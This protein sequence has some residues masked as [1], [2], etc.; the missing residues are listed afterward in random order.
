MKAN[1][2][3][4][5][6]ARERAAAVL[7]Q[8]T[9]REL[10]SPEIDFRSPHLSIQGI[11]TANDDGLIVGQGSF[12]GQPAVIISTDGHFLGGGIGEAGGAKFACALE[13]ALEDNKN[14][15]PTLPIILLDTGGVRLQEANYGLLAISEIQSLV[16]ELRKY[17][18]VIG[19][20]PGRIGCFGGMAM[21]ASLF[22]YLIMTREG[23][24]TLNGP[25]VIQLE[26]GVEEFDASNKKLI[27]DTFGV[28]SRLANG[29]ADYLARDEV[30]DIIQAVQ[31][32]IRLGIPVHRSEKIGEYQARLTSP[33]TLVMAQYKPANARPSI[34][35]RGKS[36]FNA[37][38]GQTQKNE[39]RI[40]SV[41]C[42][43]VY[44][45]G[46]NTR[47]IAVVPDASSRFPRS[48]DGEIGLE[49]GW[50]MARCI[51]SAIRED[52]G[53][54]SR[55]IIAIVDSPGQ[56]FGYV[57]EKLGIF[58]SCA[59]AANAYIDARFAGHPVISLIVGSAASG[60]FLAHGLQGSQMIA[61]DDLKITVN[62][63]S[64]KSA[65][66]I[67]KRTADELEY[68]ASIIPGAAFDIASF[69]CLGALNHLVK[70]DDADHP[71]AEDRT[72]IINV[73]AEAVLQAR[74]N[75][76][77]LQ[78]RYLNENAL[79]FRALS[80]NVRSTMRELWRN[81]Q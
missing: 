10:P 24:L 15:T 27:W 38:S 58:L 32:F 1:S 47:I 40:N 80:I 6:N 70:V 18:P 81:K 20:I 21:T 76:N 71:T 65:A 25:E 73:L 55:P 79:K 22:S 14:G 51:Q 17:Q 59:A 49:Q 3:T 2:F 53:K 78:Y 42:S 68:A 74:N 5:L 37:L 72:A 4:G 30:D 69:N 63:M 16:V 54:T 50:E 8:G 33:E 31:T 62:A 44:L 41:L 7:D 34:F 61:L 48:R 43:D 56:A 19:V 23:R 29:F 45:N 66:R 75:G 64:R 39:S 9:F 12:N 46:E 60:A 11:A 77:S 57:E 52:Q 26:A 36:W 13:L 67:T 35:T 28:V